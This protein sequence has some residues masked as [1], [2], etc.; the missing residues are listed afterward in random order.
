[1]GAL[2]PM[3]TV[4]S[5]AELFVALKCVF[6]SSSLMLMLAQWLSIYGIPKHS[7]LAGFTP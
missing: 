5:R 1:M 6:I 4:S 2:H 7:L 3:S